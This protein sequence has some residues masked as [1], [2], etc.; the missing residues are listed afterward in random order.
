MLRAL[1][2]GPGTGTVGGP[3]T[4][5]DG[6]RAIEVSVWMDYKEDE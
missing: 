3:W 5:D 2:I 1:K 4:V 6:R